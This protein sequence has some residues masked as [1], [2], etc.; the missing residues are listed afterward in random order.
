MARRW[1]K[2]EKKHTIDRHINNFTALSGKTLDDVLTALQSVAAMQKGTVVDLTTK[3]AIAASKLSL[4][5]ELEDAAKV[6]AMSQEPGIRKWI[7]DQVYKDERNAIEV[8][9]YLIAQYRDKE[10]PARTPC[11]LGICLKS[12]SELIGHVGLSPLGSQIEIGYA[13]EVKYQNRGYASQAVTAM[14]EWGIQYFSLPLIVGVVSSENASSCGVLEHAGFSLAK[15]AMGQLHGRK[16]IVR[17]YHK[18]S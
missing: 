13:I 3:I 17:T 12:S 8:L 2:C 5:I 4:Q 18:K 16:G 6:F 10:A 15:E 14:S 7:P 9:Q 11:V 1:R